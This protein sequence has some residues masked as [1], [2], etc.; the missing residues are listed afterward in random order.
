MSPWGGHF[1]AVVGTYEGPVFVYT[2]CKRVRKVRVDWYAYYFFFWVLIV[3]IVVQRATRSVVSH[4]DND[5]IFLI[6]ALPLF[7]YGMN[8]NI[9]PL[10]IG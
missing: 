2:D 8:S 7:I 1:K 5:N 10:G 9:I 3:D 4:I 6:S